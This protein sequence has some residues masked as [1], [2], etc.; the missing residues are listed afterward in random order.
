MNEFKISLHDLSIKTIIGVLEEERIS[1]QEI[2]INL[3]LIYK[4]TKN[5]IDYAEI[6]NLIKEIFEKNH[7]FYLEEAIE[8]VIDSIIKKFANISYLN[9]NIAKPSILPNCKVSVEK[10]VLLN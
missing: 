2:I 4:K 3:N 5:I 1:P 8:Y 9:L 7:F 10:E 6:Y